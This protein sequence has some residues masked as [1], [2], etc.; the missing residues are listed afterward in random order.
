MVY[1]WLA[2]EDTDDT[3][4][5]A[6]RMVDVT[7]TCEDG[8]VMMASDIDGKMGTRQSRRPW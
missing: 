5:S 8:S 7:V 1:L 3:L 6:R 4:P 2:G